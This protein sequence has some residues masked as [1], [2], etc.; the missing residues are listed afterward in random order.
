MHV[1]L[2]E[3]KNFMPT[4]NG[5][6]RRHATFLNFVRIPNGMRL[7]L[8]AVGQRPTL[9]IVNISELIFYHF[10]YHHPA[11]RG[12]PHKIDVCPQFRNIYRIEN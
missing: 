4:A 12:Y 8:F 10:P 2:S 9:L 5:A 6:C 3:A 1:I 7:S 11:L